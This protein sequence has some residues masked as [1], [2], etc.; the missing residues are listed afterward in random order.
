MLQDTAISAGA[1]VS[2]DGIAET[3]NN[4]DEA[5]DTID[6]GTVV[7]TQL[8]LS[9]LLLLWTDVLAAVLVYVS[10]QIRKY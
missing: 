7:G 8:Y 10:Y 6:K 5:L 3:F 4:D 2:E 1:I 9:S